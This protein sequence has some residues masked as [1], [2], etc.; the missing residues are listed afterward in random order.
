MVK[1][2][3]TIL[4]EPPGTGKTYTVAEKALEII[5]PQQYKKIMG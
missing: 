3:N 5:M 1:D 2:K 4:Y